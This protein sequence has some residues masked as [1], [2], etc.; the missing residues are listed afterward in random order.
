MAREQFDTSGVERGP[1]GIKRYTGRPPSLTAMLRRSVDRAPDDEAIVEVGGERVSYREL[2]DRASRVAGGLRAAGLRPGDRAAIRLGNGLAWVLAFWGCQLAGVVAVPV[3]TRLTDEEADYV[4][5]DSGASYVFRPGEP[6]PDAGPHA[7]ENLARDDLAAIFYTSGTTGF[8]KGAMTTHGNFLANCETVRRVMR[9]PGSDTALRN[10]VSVPLFHVT[11]CN[12]QLLPTLELGGATVVM[13]QFEVGEFLRTTVEERI[14]VLISVPA[15]YWL[16]INQPAFADTDVTSVTRVLY[17]GAPIAPE[18]VRRI[19]RA[20]PGARVSNAFGLTETASVT[21]CLPHEYASEHADSVGFPAP[22]VDLDLFERDPRTGVG[23]LLV[24]AP[25]VV[26]GYWN[27]PEATRDTLTCTRW[28][29]RTCSPPIPRYSRRRWSGCRTK[30]W[31]R[32]SVRSSCRCRASPRVPM[33]WSPCAVSSWRTS[34]FPSM[35]PCAGTHCP[36]TPEERCS[37]PGCA[38]AW[39][40][41]TRCSKSVAGVQRRQS[42][43][44]RWRA[45]RRCCAQPTVRLGFSPQFAN[46]RH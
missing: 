25:N 41:A 12:S 11:G 13:P 8:P 21:T 28:K 20:F 42:S 17:G 15:I 33:T 37:S 39:T 27:K 46:R 44:L 6:L 45:G 23:E 26:A 10:L 2:W 31:A 22:V 40:G 34:R 29:S 32:R 1:D 4:V 7:V 14:S 18:L 36:A 38:T 30:S 35:L 16:A 3:N 24:R 19:K 9:L 5:T 43:L